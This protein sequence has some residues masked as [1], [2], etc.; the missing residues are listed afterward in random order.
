MNIANFSIAASQKFFASML[1]GPKTMS[2]TSDA[3]TAQQESSSQAMKSPEDVIEPPPIIGANGTD[4]EPLHPVRTKLFE[5]ASKQKIVKVVDKSD[6]PG[7]E[8]SAEL[9]K[10]QMAVHNA[11]E[12]PD[13]P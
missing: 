1:N 7:R 8:T 13:Y 2:T 5:R 10:I 4:H 12:T 9:R 3:E 6:V 11:D